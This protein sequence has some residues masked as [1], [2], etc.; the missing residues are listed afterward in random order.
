MEA[1]KSS[2]KK[3]TLKN[4][5]I[6]W[7][8][9]VAIKKP[10][11]LQYRIA[12]LLVFKSIRSKLG[13]NIKALVCGS[14]ALQKE[15]MQTFSGIGIPIYEGYGMT[16]T[17]PVVS[18]NYKD[19]VKA[20]TVGKPVEGVKVKI[21]HDGEILVK[22]DNVMKAYYRRT[23]LTNEVIDKND[24]FHSGDLGM[25]DEDGYLIITGRKKALFKTSGGKYINPELLETAFRTIPYI[26][27]IMIVGENEKFPAALIVPNFKIV[28]EALSLEYELTTENINSDPKLL[29]L[30][31]KEIDGINQQFGH[32]EQIK[33]FVLLA[34]DWT[35]ETGEL[36][37]KLTLRRKAI[38]EKFSETI[39]VIYIN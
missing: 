7:A 36:T 39:K 4:W 8:L 22:G 14:A 25:I 16:E 17:S 21:A 26:Q 1:I 31:Q 33:K 5:L 28:N 30:F 10:A 13:N 12:E 20:G 35:V 9:E 24:Y 32:W 34:Q 38:L 23:D 6:T 2:S 18:V 19:N 3:G 29:Q 15:L 11:A 27:Q 37:P